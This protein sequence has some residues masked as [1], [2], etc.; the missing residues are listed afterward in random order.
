MYSL[1]STEAFQATGGEGE[2]PGMGEMVIF[3]ADYVEKGLTI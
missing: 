2:M 1:L 3:D